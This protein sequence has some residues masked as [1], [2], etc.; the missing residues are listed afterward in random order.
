MA[1]V[2]SSTTV[3]PGDHL[4]T[5]GEHSG[6]GPLDR[7]FV[8]PGRGHDVD[9]VEPT[10]GAQ[11]GLGGGD[12]EGGEGGAGQVVRRAEP[13]QADDGERAGRAHEEDP[14]PLPH[15]E[16][17]LLCRAQVHDDL[18]GRVGCVTP[19]ETEDRDPLVGVVGD[20][21]GGCAPGRHGLSGRA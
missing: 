21:D 17:V 8:D 2:A 12:V 10:L 16:A 14:Y 3:R 19:D 1:L 11:D 13:G 4:D 18:V 20:P 9:G 7:V 5:A 6:D 15:L